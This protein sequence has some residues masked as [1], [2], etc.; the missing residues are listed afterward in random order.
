MTDFVARGGVRE[1]EESGVNLLALSAGLLPRY[2]L[3]LSVLKRGVKHSGATAP[4]LRS[5]SMT[6]YMLCEVAELRDEHVKRCDSTAYDMVSEDCRPVD[7]PR[8]DASSPL[9]F[10]LAPVIASVECWSA[11][12]EKTAA[13][14]AAVG[15]AGASGTRR[16][17]NTS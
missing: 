16:Q 13:G 9:P 11:A 3:V 12:A 1:I 17:K 10:D 7:M 4:P 2:R 6:L 14:S 15:G 5:Y 8:Y